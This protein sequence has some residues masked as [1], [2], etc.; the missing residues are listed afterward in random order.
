M[1][2]GCLKKK[3]A[4]TI[5]FFSFTPLIHTIRRSTTEAADFLPQNRFLAFSN[6]YF[7]RILTGNRRGYSKHE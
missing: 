7:L 5:F 1:Q 2:G 6:G 3:S 4:K